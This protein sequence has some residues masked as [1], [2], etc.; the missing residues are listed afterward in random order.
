MYARE[1]INIEVF[2]L[3]DSKPTVMGIQSVLSILDDHSKRFF[4]NLTSKSEDTDQKFCEN[5]YRSH[6]P[7]A[8]ERRPV[9]GPLLPLKMRACRHGTSLGLSDGFVVRHYAG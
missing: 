7:A 3:P 4:K 1:K 5:V 8:L 2:E 6:M 9:T